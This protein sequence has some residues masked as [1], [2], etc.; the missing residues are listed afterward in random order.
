[1]RG[2][3][4]PQAHM[5]SYFSPEDR[6]PAKHPLRSIKAYTDEAL[7]RIR[8]V[9][10]GIYSTIGRPSIPPERLLKAQLLIALYSVRSDRLFC[11]TLDYNILF[12]WFLDMGLEEPSFDASTFSKNRE[13]LS[14]EDVALKFFDAVVREA[15]VLELLSDEHFS[16][17]GTLI[18]AWASMKSFRPK[19]GGGSGPDAG[20]DHHHVADRHHVGGVGKVV[21]GGDVGQPPLETLVVPQREAAGVSEHGQVTD[22][23]NGHGIFRG[24]GEGDA[25]VG[26]ADSP[27]RSPV[28]R[29]AQRAGRGVVGGRRFLSKHSFHFGVHHSLNPFSKIFSMAFVPSRNP[30]SFP[31]SHCSRNFNAR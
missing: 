27:G 29:G 1:M 14:G 5:F 28:L 22:G 20:G 19:D 12:R 25:G 2:H 18:E 15:R 3:V 13:R 17:D 26:L 16:V 10:D 11:E 7:K 4:I 24:L 9:L 31:A 30:A 21:A 6:V 8:P 23:E